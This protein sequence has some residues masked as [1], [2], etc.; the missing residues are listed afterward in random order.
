MHGLVCF[1]S[2]LLFAHAD[3]GSGQRA[4]AALDFYVHADLFLNPSAELADI[5]L[6]AATPFETEGLKIGFEVSAGA[7]AHV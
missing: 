3:G 6:P 7:N 2:N 4:L 1:G 5:V